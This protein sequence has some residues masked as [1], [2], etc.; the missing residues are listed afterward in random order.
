MASPT[1]SAS[2]TVPVGSLDVYQYT[3]S[4]PPKKIPQPRNSQP[5]TFIWGPL[6]PRALDGRDRL[7][8][9][10]RV[11]APLDVRVMR[12]EG[13]PLGPDPRDPVEVMPRRRAGRRPFERARVSPRVFLGHLHAVPPGDVHVP[14]EHENG[15]GQNPRPDGGDDVE[16]GHVAG[17]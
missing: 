16:R 14:E 7:L 12:L 8:D 11:P 3:M 1:H 10:G 2:E 15:Q 9:P 17:Q 6:L 5:S 13:G 4:V